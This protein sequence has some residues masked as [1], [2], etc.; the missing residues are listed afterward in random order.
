MVVEALHV[1]DRVDAYGV[2]V[3][4]GAGADDD[5]LAADSSLYILVHRVHVHR[6]VG[7]CLV[8]DHRVVVDRSIG[9]A[10]R[11]V[12]GK[13]GES[14]LEWTTSQSLKPQDSTSLRAASRPAPS[15]TGRVKDN[16]TLP[17]SIVSPYGLTSFMTTSPGRAPVRVPGG[18]ERV[19]IPGALP[20]QAFE[21]LAAVLGPLDLR[22]QAFF[23]GIEHADLLHVLH[24][25]DRLLEHLVGA[26]RRRCRPG[27]NSM[28]S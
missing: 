5:D 22:E 1:H 10:V 15:G 14:A 4:A 19:E 12:E 18:L 17:S 16:C 8:G 25:F 23:Y 3:E 28:S 6:G 11:H 20:D 9:L 13:L 26:A 2:R 21:A 24:E 7:G 27:L